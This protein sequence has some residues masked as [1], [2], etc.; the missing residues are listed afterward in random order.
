M[1]VTIGLKGGGNKKIIS[2]GFIGLIRV[3][4]KNYEVFCN[5]N[6]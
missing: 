6:T 5:A 3:I 1:T 4:Y 2:R